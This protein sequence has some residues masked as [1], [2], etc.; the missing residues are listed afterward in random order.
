[1][2][3]A[4]CWVKSE[5]L[6]ADKSAAMQASYG[7]MRNSSRDEDTQVFCNMLAKLRI[8]VEEDDGLHNEVCSELSA[9][10]VEKWFDVESDRNVVEALRSDIAE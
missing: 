8:T 5:C 2:T 10:D 4:R 9:D 3:I 1:M 7:R 6:P